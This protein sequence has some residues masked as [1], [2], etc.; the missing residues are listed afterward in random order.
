MKFTFGI[1]TENTVSDEVLQSIIQQNVSEY[2]IIIIGGYKDWYKFPNIRH[3]EFDETIKP[4]WLTKKKNLI[5]ENA[6]YENIVYMHDYVTLEPNWYKGF[7]EI[8]DNWD[9]CMTI[10]LNKDGTR[11]RDWCAWD[12]PECCYLAN[13][14]HWGCLVPYNYSKTQYMYI[15]GAYWVAK[16]HVMT[17]EPLDENLCW[18]EGEDVDWSFRFRD[19]YR[20]KMNIWSSAK[21]LKQK[22]LLVNEA[23][24]DD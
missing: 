15:S 24:Y 5:T 19:K 18:G 8:D 20:Y 22:D 11:Y 9:V 10:L 2:E 13:G 23:R 4:A 6:S 17:E 3:F 16:K 21:L 1:V 12:D 7:Q 14:R